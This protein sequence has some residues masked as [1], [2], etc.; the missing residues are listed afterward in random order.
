V[1][2]FLF[3]KYIL[4]IFVLKKFEHTF[5]CL[6]C[7]IRFNKNNTN[8]LLFWHY[9]LNNWLS[10]NNQTNTDEDER[11]LYAKIARCSVC[12][13]TSSGVGFSFHKQSEQTEKNL[14]LR[15]R[16]VAATAQKDSSFCCSTAPTS[17]T[18]PPPANFAG[19]LLLL[20]QAWRISVWRGL[21]SLSWRFGTLWAL[22]LL[23]L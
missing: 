19:A 7:L 1:S 6:L 22:H 15:H 5:D 10:I 4:V 21:F 3:S 13:N 23:S 12:K 9:V 18:P 8:I 20:R 2:S 16:F 11:C 14:N 17:R